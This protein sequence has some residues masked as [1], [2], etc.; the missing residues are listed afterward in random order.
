MSA[1]PQSPERPSRNLTYEAIHQHAPK[2]PA[3]QRG[4]VFGFGDFMSITLKNLQSVLNRAWPHNITRGSSLRHTTGAFTLIELLVVIA[5]IAILAA[6]LLPALNR[7]KLKATG[8]V[9]LSNQKQHALAFVMFADDNADVMPPYNDFDGRKMIGGGYWAGPLLGGFPIPPAMSWASLSVPQ[10]EAAVTAGL[11]KGPLW[12]YMKAF[13]A[14]HC[15][16]DLRSRQP[17]STTWAWDSYWRA[18]GMNGERI[19]GDPFYFEPLVKLTS[20]PGP[21]ESIIFAE[22]ADSRHYNVG[23]WWWDVMEEAPI[24]SDPVACFHGN[25]SSFSMA[26]GH[27]E[28]HRWLTPNVIKSG[29]AAATGQGFTPWVKDVTND[30]DWAWVKARYKYK[31]WPGPPIRN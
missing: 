16:G 9:C 15:P 7:A 19:P 4:G 1:S 5:I 11:A 31:N 13:G 27:A 12:N 10:A 21:A 22:G 14:Y 3:R 23:T 6:M 2:I 18:N 8:A 24:R 29:T 28:M 26:D 17:T 20:V 30:P 25:I